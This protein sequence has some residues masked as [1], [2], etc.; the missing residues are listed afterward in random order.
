MRVS[1]SVLLNRTLL[2]MCRLRVQ[3]TYLW[4]HGRLANID[5]PELLTEHVQR[6]KLF[7]RDPRLPVLADKVLVKARVG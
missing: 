2:R 1:L 4:R 7:S 3:T 6:R 5:D